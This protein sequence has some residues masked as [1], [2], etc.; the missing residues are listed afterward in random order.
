MDAFK[1]VKHSK[2][3]GVLFKI[4]L[5]AYSQKGCKNDSD[6]FILDGF[7]EP[8]SLQVQRKCGYEIII[9]YH[10]FWQQFFND[11]GSI[12]E[13][14][15]RPL[16]GPGK[17]NEPIFGLPSSPGSQ[18]PLK[19]SWKNVWYFIMISYPHV[20]WNWRDFGSILDPHGRP[21]GGPGKPNEPIFG[22]PSSPGSQNGSKTCP[23]SL[24][25]HSQTSIFL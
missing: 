4:T 8:D 15:G 14:H 11:F 13:P 1:V 3:Y 20:L 22:L 10:T 19:N 21:L 6:T 25:G 23:K 7:F 5:F 2:N 9:K 16:G 17:P 24:L 18:N 12:L